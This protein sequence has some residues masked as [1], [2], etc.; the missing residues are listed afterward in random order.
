MGAASARQFFLGN[1]ELVR[2]AGLDDEIAAISFPDAARYRA[3]E[4]TVSETFEDGL[5]QPVKRLP[6]LRST[7]LKRHG[8]ELIVRHCT[9]A[10]SCP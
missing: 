9:A 6:K 10:L 2:L 4:V 3:T 7:R 5:N 8:R 1:S